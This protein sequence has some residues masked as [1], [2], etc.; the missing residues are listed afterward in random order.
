MIFH[1]VGP[2]GAGKST[3]GIALATRLGVP[4]VD[5]DSEFISRVGAIS[6]V[7]NGDGYETYARSNVDTYL[8]VADPSRSCVI[9]LSSG[10]MVY[11]DNIHSEYTRIRVDIAESQSTFVLLPSLDLE[12][13]VRETVQRQLTRPFCR[14]AEKEESVI[15]ER[16]AEYV[17]LPAKKVE[18]MVSIDAVV[19]QILAALPPNTLAP[20]QLRWR[21]NGRSV[22]PTGVC[23][24]KSIVFSVV[25][26]F[27]RCLGLSVNVVGDFQVTA[28]DVRLLGMVVAHGR[29][30][31][32][33][34]N[35]P[36]RRFAGVGAAD[37]DIR[38]T[39]R[40][41]RSQVDRV[42]GRDTIPSMLGS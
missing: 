22:I 39:D 36:R 17:K 6:R 34:C 35:G 10:F 31:T 30:I 41:R 2:G 3:V 32:T 4:F 20:D 11:P 14:S 19:E 5:L 25:T 23:A 8:T 7:I 40:G 33:A 13:C 1:L 28:P 18:T 21:V 42:H 37:A 9:A 27:L 15:R 24:S 26:P 16:Y 29:G 12:K 38:Y